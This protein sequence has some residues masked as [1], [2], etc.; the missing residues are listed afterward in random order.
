MKRLSAV[1][2]IL[3]VGA[4][5]SV[6]QVRDASASINSGAKLRYA[7]HHVGPTDIES[8]S[9]DFEGKIIWSKNA[10]ID[11]LFVQQKGKVYRIT[12]ASVMKAMTDATVPLRRSAIK[13]GSSNYRELRAKE[14]EAVYAKADKIVADAMAKGLGKVLAP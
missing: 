13:P 10:K 7:F 3:A 9:R 12:D 2:A 11:E 1:V 4:G 14:R 6:A 5:L 8:L